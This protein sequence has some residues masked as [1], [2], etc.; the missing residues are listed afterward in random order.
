MW[1]NSQLPVP[2]AVSL[3]KPKENLVIYPVSG[4][5]GN[6]KNDV[7]ECII[8]IDLTKQ[9]SPKKSACIT[10]FFK[11]I[12]SDPIKEESEVK[13]ELQVKEEPKVKE[14]PVFDDIPDVWDISFDDISTESTHSPRRSRSPSRSPRRKATPV[15]SDQLLAEVSEDEDDNKQTEGGKKRKREDASGANSPTKRQKQN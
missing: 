9:S 7:P 11:S 1:L 4:V 2:E 14:E 10:S 13:S 12:K 8:P 15:T 3:L 6:F 5:V